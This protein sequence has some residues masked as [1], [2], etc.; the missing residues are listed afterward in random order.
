MDLFNQGKIYI[1]SFICEHLYM[2][3][4]PAVKDES[5]KVK[6]IKNGEIFL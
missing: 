6:N 5:I 4:L 2:H 3:S 1:H